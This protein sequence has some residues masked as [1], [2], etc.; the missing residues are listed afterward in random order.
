[1]R[2]LQG[3]KWGE[4]RVDRLILFESLKGKYHPRVEVPLS[5]SP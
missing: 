5:K 2:A 3:E 1:V 4:A